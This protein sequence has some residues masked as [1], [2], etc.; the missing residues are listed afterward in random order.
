MIQRF[1][2]RSVLAAPVI[3]SQGQVLA[4]FEV[5]NKKSNTG[6]GD[7]PGRSWK[8]W[9]RSPPLPFKTPNSTSTSAI[10][11]SRLSAAQE[12]ERQRLS[13]ELHDSTGQ[14]LTALG[15][16]LAMLADRPEAAAIQQELA[17]ATELTHEDSRRNPRHL[18]GPAP[19]NAGAVRPGRDPAHALH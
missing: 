14:M 2:L 12:E 17:E 10:S 9:R 7:D 3:D 11:A 13:R 8:G 6:F 4:F 1:G 19:A 15:M 5:V 18:P 16:Q